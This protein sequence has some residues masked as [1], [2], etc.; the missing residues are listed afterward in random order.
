MALKTTVVTEIPEGY[1]PSA[2]AANIFGV[3][4]AT[5]LKFL[6]TAAG[7]YTS[8]KTTKPGFYLNPAEFTEDYNLARERA[9]ALRVENGKRLGQMSKDRAA[10]KKAANDAAAASQAV[11]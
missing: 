10:A 1:V 7:N 6:R 2:D 4:A 5:L 3:S 9:A 8:F 11:A